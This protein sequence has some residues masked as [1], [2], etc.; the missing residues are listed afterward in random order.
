MAVQFYDPA[1]L[2]SQEWDLAVHGE[3][4]FQ[5]GTIFNDTIPFAHGSHKAT[6]SRY[7]IILDAWDELSVGVSGN[8]HDRVERVLTQVRS[9]FLTNRNPPIR[10]ILTGRPSTA[11]E[12]SRFLR[13]DTPLLTI[14]PLSPTNLLDLVNRLRL[15][16]ARPS[17]EECRLSIPLDIETFEPALHAYEENHRIKQKA[18]RD[19]AEH[20]ALDVLGLPLLAQ[21][22]VRL[23]VSQNVDPESLTSDPTTL[24]RRLVDL[25][26]EEGGQ[27]VGNVASLN[28]ARRFRGMELR[29]LLWHTASAIT[30]RY[31]EAIS[32]EELYFRMQEL[33]GSGTLAGMLS[34][35]KLTSSSSRDF[36]ENILVS[37]YFKTG[38]LE[39][40]CEFAH[41]SFREYLFAEA[42][43]EELKEHALADSPGSGKRSAFWADF[44]ETDR[45]HRL[46]RRLGMLLAP[47]WLSAEVERHVSELIAWEVSRSNEA[48][49]VPHP[50]VDRLRAMP[51]ES[52]SRESWARIRDDLA[53][54]WEWWGEGAHLRPQIRLKTGNIQGWDGTLYALK[55]IEWSLPKDFARRAVL[56][57]APQRTV[58]VDAQLGAGLFLLCV[59]THREIAIGNSSQSAEAA[60]PMNS[61]PDQ[62]I[63]F[64]RSYQSC[65]RQQGYNE[66]LFFPSSQ[67]NY[68]RN[69]IARMNAS[70]W[71]PLGK[72]PW[73]ADLGAVDLRMANLSGVDLSGADLS[74]ADLSGA[75][76]SR[77]NLFKANLCRVNLAG[78]N[79][80]EAN[81][82]EADLSG[83]YLREVIGLTQ[84]QFHSARCDARTKLPPWLI[85]LNP[86]TLH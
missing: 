13:D 28:D 49:D 59:V 33:D 72:F 6:I 39:A 38:N 61:A 1:N 43:V 20:S 60:G 69:Y 32:G 5:G 17:S 66:V 51:T 40:G 73:R 74:D 86:G 30:V 50:Q 71:R 19:D 75:N 76:L 81:F 47:R 37:Y 42:I 56:P 64:P 67:E 46:S 68:L 21:V 57:P 11:V 8:L 27:V 41:K 70:G 36:L 29:R 44:E 62:A 7:V 4:I 54:L 84:D 35:E 55:L 31:S 25:T 10:V 3:D 26:C 52:I 79:V 14:R 16:F 2:E 12:E 24:Y 65:R 48:N 85:P 34:Q 63:D 80:T 77:S 82:V 23:V 18:D 15:A 78:T 9:E 53:D 22:V 45:R 58:A 83:A